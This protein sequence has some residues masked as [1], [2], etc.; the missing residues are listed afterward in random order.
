VKIKFYAHA[1][2]RLEGDGLT[3]VTDP[4]TPGPEGSNFAPIEEPADIVIM[5]SATD[6][7]HSNPNHVLGEP[8]IINAL[9]IPPEGQ[10][11]KGLHI[12]AYPTSESLTHDFG[13]D[14]DANAI[15]LFTL[16]GVRCMHMGDVGNPLPEKYLTALHGN[17]DVLFAL[18]GGRATIAL[19]D[20]DEAIRAISPRLVIPM[21]YF[22]ERGVLKILPITDFT[23][24]YPSDQITWVEGSELELS[25]HS[26]PEALRIYV[27]QESR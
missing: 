3:V 1:S 13:R 26:L 10:T 2:F 14:P 11:V 16:G 5:S 24:R 20:L 19:D 27:L 12:L 22:N 25:P 9:E 7:F 15:Y 18:A 21:H 23:D 6:R 4:Y 17:V 8:I